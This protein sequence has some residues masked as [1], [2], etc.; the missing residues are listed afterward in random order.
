MT[1][2][3]VAHVEAGGL[4]H[5]YQEGTELPGGLSVTKLSVGPYDNNAY[6]LAD[7]DAGEALLVDAANEPE[8][9]LDL[10]RGLTLL[11]VVT[12][13]RHAD[14]TY[15]LRDVLRATNAWSAAHPGD[16]DELPAAP[17]RLVEDGDTITVGGFSV[18]VVHTPGHTDGSICLKLPHPQI[19]TGD[20][21][22]PGGVG[23]TNGTTAFAQAI[24][25]VER[26]VFTLPTETRI[27]P[28]HGDDTLVGTEAPHLEEWRARGW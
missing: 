22:F 27:S 9:L 8:R 20:A 6:V 21:L 23:K 15:A 4:P 7:I 18:S 10:L 2:F 13:H 17:D 25:S 19:L 5:H 26:N 16:A 28:G 3:D 12:T 24:G 14:H 1:S 11:G